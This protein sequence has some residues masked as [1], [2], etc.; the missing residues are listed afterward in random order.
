MDPLRAALQSLKS[1][2]LGESPN[3]TQV[4][5]KYGCERSTLSRRHRGVQGTYAAKTE[6]ERLLTFTQEKELII[7]I[8]GLTGRGLPPTRQMIRNFASEIA[9]KEAGKSW[10]DQFIKRHDIN[11]V[12]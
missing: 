3:Y 5:K 11:F 8:D 6:N 1:L 9:G 7:Y 2:K 10:V 12:S 4:A